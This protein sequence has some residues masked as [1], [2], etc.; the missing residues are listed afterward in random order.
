MRPKS[1]AVL[2]LAIGCGLVATIGFL[3]LRPNIE[4][5][6]SSGETQTVFIANVDVGLGD[7]LTPQM[8]K[9]D[10]WPKEKVPPGAVTRIEDAEGRRVRTRLYAGEP[11]LE[12]KLMGKGASQQ[13]ATSLIPKG[14]RVVPVRVDAESSSNLILPGD[15]VDVMLHVTRDVGRQLPQTV[16]RTILQDIKVFAVNDVLDLEKEKE[17]GRSINAK[18]ISLLVSPDQAAKLMLA[19]QMGKC[20]LV[21]RSPED[22]VQAEN[23]QATPAELFGKTSKADRSKETLMEEL[24]VAPKPAKKSSFLSLLGAM[25]TKT[26]TANAAKKTWTMRILQPGAVNDIVLESDRSAAGKDSPNALWRTRSATGAPAAGPLPQAQAV[27]PSPPQPG[28]QPSPT[29]EPPPVKEPAAESS[30]APPIEDA[31][32][33][34]EGASEDSDPTIP[35]NKTAAVKKTD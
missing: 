11:I 5:T 14:Y 7:L 16:T 9:L 17:P 1:L 2:M 23:A 21:M 12:S 25:Q 10:Q 34:D 22:D 8:L 18:T 15:R 13:G 4:A 3:R 30:N 26:P 24:D 6:P 20:L 33:A 27:I 35:S 31:K 29:P 28:S 32:P 19:G